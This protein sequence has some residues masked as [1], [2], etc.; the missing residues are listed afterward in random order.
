MLV[1]VL[2]FIKQLV[3]NMNPKEESQQKK[4]LNGTTT[5]NDVPPSSP[6]IEEVEEGDDS[7][8]DD[9]N[10]DD[11]WDDSKGVVYLNKL[12]EDDY[13]CCK[14]ILQNLIS[15]GWGNKTCEMIHKILEKQQENRY[16]SVLRKLKYLQ[17]QSASPSSKDLAASATSNKSGGDKKEQRLTKRSVICKN[18]IDKKPY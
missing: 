11:V 7:M 16:K 9:N 18:K 2:N 14:T 10:D 5:T 8:S 1:F 4:A 12:K 13:G 17:Q 3:S 6:E 15:L